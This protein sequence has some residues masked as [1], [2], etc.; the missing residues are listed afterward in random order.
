MGNTELAKTYA[1]QGNYRGIA[2]L[3]TKIDSRNIVYV[4]QMVSV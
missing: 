3:L 1:E 4:E 2:W